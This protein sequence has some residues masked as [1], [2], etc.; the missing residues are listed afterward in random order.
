MIPLCDLYRVIGRRLTRKLLA[1]GWLVPERADLRACVFDPQKVHH[2]LSRLARESS[3]LAPLWKPRFPSSKQ[4]NQKG[5]DLEELAL[6]DD[7]FSSLGI[8]SGRGDTAESQ[9]PI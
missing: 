9:K 4:S 8:Q 1:A 6:G 5:V 7:D 2:A 3:T